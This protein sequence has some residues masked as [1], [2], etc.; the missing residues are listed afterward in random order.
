MGLIQFWQRDMPLP[1]PRFLHP[2]ADKSEELE[3]VGTMVSHLLVVKQRL[4]AYVQQMSTIGN[5]TG[6]WGAAVGRLRRR[7]HHDYGMPLESVLLLQ[8]VG[9]HVGSTAL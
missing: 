2:L 4:S 5:F 3:P 9:D 8:A 7:G 1:V 6:I